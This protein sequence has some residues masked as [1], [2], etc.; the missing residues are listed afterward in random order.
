MLGAGWLC[1]GGT[2]T[3]GHILAIGTGGYPLYQLGS[4][5]LWIMGRTFRPSA[6]PPCS[7]ALCRWGSGVEGW[8]LHWQAE[9]VC[10][11]VCYLEEC[12]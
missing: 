9:V 10:A 5:A 6:S 3:A 4:L 7:L 2:F 11:C 12:H 8:W 1:V